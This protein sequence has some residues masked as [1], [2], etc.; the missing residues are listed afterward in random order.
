MKYNICFFLLFVCLCIF[1]CKAS[2]DDVIATDP[3]EQD[4]D[5]DSITGDDYTYTLPVIF[6]VLYQNKDSA[7]QYVEHKR[8]KTILG[9]VNELYQGNVYGTSENIHV[10]F[11]LAQYDEKGNKLSTPGV[12]YI[13]YTGTYPIDCDEF[14]GDNSNKHYIWDPNEYINVML[15]NFK[16]TNE[17][18]T[19]LG[20]SN[21]PY[22]ASDGYPQLE[23]LASVSRITLTKNNLKHPYCISI[24]SLYVYNESTRYTDQYKGH[25]GYTYDRTD[26][27]VTL[28]HELGHYLGLHHVF[29]EKETEKGTEIADSC[30][31]TDYC[32][33]T[34]SYNYNEYVDWVKYFASQKHEEK[35]T[36][37]TL[38]TRTNCDGELWRSANLMDYS[39]CYSDE[40]TEDQHY[41]M[42]QVLYYSP[43]IPGPKKAR[44]NAAKSRASELLVSDEPLDLPVRLA[45]R[46]IK[47]TPSM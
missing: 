12:E 28:A 15:Y 30:A 42:R 18:S 7:L 19:T 38:T 4:R 16:N 39:Y 11:V 17:N 45:K 35:I 5:N 2:D 47:N 36:V 14:M 37:D 32:D 21:M 23:G 41:R 8:L 9:Y 24:N 40:F 26:V 10:N 43:L 13:K 3:I 1:S 33:D 31:D 25:K 22:V 34:K 6:H 20:I 29:T 46:V 44:P 27:N